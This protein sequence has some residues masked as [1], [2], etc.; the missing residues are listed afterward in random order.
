LQDYALAAFYAHLRSVPDTAEKEIPVLMERGRPIRENLL[1]MAE[2][3]VAFKIFNGD[4]VASIR[5]GQGNIDT[6]KDLVALATL[7]NAN[8]DKVENK[9]PFG[10]ELVRDAA[11]IGANLLHAIGVKEVGEVRNDTSYDWPSLRARSFRLLM[12]AYEEARR[13]TAFLRWHHGDAHAFAPSLHVFSRK[14][15][16]PRKGDEQEQPQGALLGNQAGLLQGQ[17]TQTYSSQGQSNTGQPAAE[18]GMPGSS[19]FES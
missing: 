1:V 13:A 8:W 17:S 18:P 11:N 5:E 7:F 15:T 12:N 14:Q 19:P 3:L 16:L 6:A 2:A 4:L 9:V 10:L